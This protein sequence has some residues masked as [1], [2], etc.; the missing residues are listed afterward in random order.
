MT[1]RRLLVVTTPLWDETG[2]PV[3][4]V[5]ASVGLL[6]LQEGLR[7]AEL[8]ENSS[9]LV[10]DHGGR[11]VTRRQDPEQWVGRSALE[12]S[13]VQDALK[14]RDGVS[15]GNFVDGVRRLSGFASPESVPWVVVVGVPTDEAYATLWR[16]L[17]RSLARLSVAGTIAVAVAWLLSRRL[18]RPVG[19]LARR[20]PGRTPPATS[21][22]AS[23]DSGP[24]EVA[25]LGAT[26]NRMAA[27]LQRQLAELEGARRR[28]RLAGAQALVELQRLHSEF[29]AIASHE[30]RTPVAAAK[31][32]AELLLRE[33]PE[34]APA[35]RR[36]AL[37]RLDAVCERLARLV[38]SLLGASRIQAGR[39]ELQC[40]PVDVAALVRRVLVDVTAY[41]P[42]RAIHLRLADGRATLA[43]ADAERV[44]DVLINLLANAGKFAPPGTDV[45]R[46]GR[47][48]RRRRGGDGG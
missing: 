19:R 15:E 29:I 14:R 17:W 10:V 40:E 32:Y 1:S 27:E 22:G 33:G 36:H 9:L 47:P 7:R 41:A 12:S 39:L 23:D 4:V 46:R 11:I 44:E 28:E 35:T 48:G 45:R 24:R 13:A 30:L 2:T 42:G 18:T 25:A 16:D 3:G 21:T 20:P 38:R 37:V 43:L 31:S 8:P 26:L 34:L 5:A 6:R